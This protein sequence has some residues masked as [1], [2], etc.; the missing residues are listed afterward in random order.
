MDGDEAVRAGDE[1][2]ASWSDGWHVL[3]LLWVGVRR[4]RGGDSER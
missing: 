2:F 3:C 4:A 1:D